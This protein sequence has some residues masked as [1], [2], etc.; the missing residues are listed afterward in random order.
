MNYKWENCI[1]NCLWVLLKVAFMHLLY[2][3]QYQ[4]VSKQ[5][6][7]E[8]KF[9]ILQCFI[10]TSSLELARDKKTVVF[11]GK[12][13][14]TLWPVLLQ[15]SFSLQSLNYRFLLKKY[16]G[17]A[18]VFDFLCCEEKILTKTLPP[19]VW[20]KAIKKIK[21]KLLNH[22]CVTIKMNTVIYRLFCKNTYCIQGSYVHSLA[23][24]KLFLLCQ[25]WW[26]FL[27]VL[28]STIQ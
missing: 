18:R 1:P 25:P 7:T 8:L 17:K 16:D 10:T 14:N 11:T 5:M 15:F 21:S 28:K 27:A 24:T 9:S 3:R 23:S 6:R 26:H 20:V 2:R 12:T 13:K 22:M 4:G 19:F